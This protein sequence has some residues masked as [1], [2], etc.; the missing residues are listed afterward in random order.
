[1]RQNAGL[2]RWT[3]SEVDS[4]LKEIMASIFRTCVHCA[5]K[6]AKKNDFISG[7]NIGGFLRVAQAMV[8]YG[9]I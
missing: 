6:Y 1:M 7:A 2:E 5:D 9:I 8:S 4:H 3:F